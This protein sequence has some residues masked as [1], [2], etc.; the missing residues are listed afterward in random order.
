MKVVCYNDVGNLSSAIRAN[1]EC[2]NN[3]MYFTEN[4]INISLQYSEL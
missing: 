1:Q 4:V 2:S 3:N